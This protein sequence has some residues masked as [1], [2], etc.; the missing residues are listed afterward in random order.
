MKLTGDIME[1]KYNQRSFS[2]PSLI[3]GLIHEISKQDFDYFQITYSDITGDFHKEDDTLIEFREDHIKE[4]CENGDVIY[5]N[6]SNICKITVYNSAQ[7]KEDKD[8]FDA[9]DDD[10]LWTGNRIQ[11]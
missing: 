11:F 4:T 7:S 10:D 9:F 3:K 8:E 2:Y 1:I 6:Y 5:W